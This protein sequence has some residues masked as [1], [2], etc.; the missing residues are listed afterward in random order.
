MQSDSPKDVVTPV[1]SVGD[2]SDGDEVHEQVIIIKHNILAY[3]LQL[4]KEVMMNGAT[5]QY[6]C[7]NSNQNLLCINQQPQIRDLDKT[8]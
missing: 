3:K 2:I 6:N 1:D 4:C 7:Q 5:L 8:Y